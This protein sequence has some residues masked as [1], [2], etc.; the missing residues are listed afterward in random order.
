MQYVSKSLRVPFEATFVDVL[1]KYEVDSVTLGM[2]IQ[3]SGLSFRFYYG[4]VLKEVC[5]GE[6]VEYAMKGFIWG[7]QVSAIVPP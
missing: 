2:V 5:L 1:R 4:F 6:N 3:A 7:A